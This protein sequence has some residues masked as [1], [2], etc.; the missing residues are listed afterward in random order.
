[1][2]DREAVRDMAGAIIPAPCMVIA[3]TPDGQ[4]VVLPSGER[5]C[6]HRTAGHF[7]RWPHADQ[8]DNGQMVEWR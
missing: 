8:D 7:P 2:G 3:R 4:P 6:C 1:M 5:L